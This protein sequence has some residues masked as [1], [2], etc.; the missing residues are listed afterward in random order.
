M[1]TKFDNCVAYYCMIEN[2]PKITTILFQ[3]KHAQILKN[4]IELLN[5]NNFCYIPIEMLHSGNFEGHVLVQI[6]Q[7]NYNPVKK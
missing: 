6:P 2:Q 4:D 3:R 1:Y 7:I 5:C